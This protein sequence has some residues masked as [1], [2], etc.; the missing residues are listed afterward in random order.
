MERTPVSMQRKCRWRPGM[1]ILFS[2]M[3]WP[4]DEAL[5]ARPGRSQQP[6]GKGIWSDVA[7]KATSYRATDGSCSRGLNRSGKVPW[8]ISR[9]GK[10]VFGELGGEC[11]GWTT[12]P[13]KAGAFATRSDNNRSVTTGCSTNETARE[14][15]LRPSK[16]ITGAC[17]RFFFG[18]ICR[19]SCRT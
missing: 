3:K 11:P 4:D 15:L 1:V 10:V 18:Q 9:P 12:A 19:S 6:P 8:P 14:L 2:R 13:G 17:P 7:R 5:K 16:P